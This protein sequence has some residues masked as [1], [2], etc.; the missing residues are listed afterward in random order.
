MSVFRG[1]D[2]AGMLV[3]T[4]KKHNQYE[5][6]LFREVLVAPELF[7]RAFHGG[8]LYSKKD[9][10]VRLIMGHAR[11]ATLGEVNRDNCH[12]FSFN[13]LVGC[14]NGTVPTMVPSDL[15]TDEQ[16][17]HKANDSWNIYNLMN[18]EGLDATLERIKGGAYAL[19]WVDKTND[20]LNFIRNEKRTLFFGGNGGTL[21][22]ASEKPFLEFAKTRTNI[23]SADIKEVEPHVLYQVPISCAGGIKINQIDKSHITKPKVYPVAAVGDKPWTQTE[24]EEALEELDAKETAK[25]EAPKLAIV[26]GGGSKAPPPSAIKSKSANRFLEIGTTPKTDNMRT[27]DYYQ[28]F[29]YLGECVDDPDID[30]VEEMVKENSCCGCGT[31]VSTS[32]IPNTGFYSNNP[33]DMKTFYYI[34]SQCLTEGDNF[35]VAPE[36]EE[37]VLQIKPKYVKD[38]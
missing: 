24:W 30:S 4:T 9:N 13:K 11:A 2:S 6:A 32:N 29:N 10:P 22:W 20:T 17:S 3:V 35:F 5:P 37:H 23:Y 38:N 7:R 15:T 28:V 14:H 12:P 21:Y 36:Y 18:K 26:H 1:T 27:I 19:T 25:P 16:K 34:C 8:R 33:S 31:C